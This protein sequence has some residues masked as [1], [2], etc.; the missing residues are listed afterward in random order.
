MDDYRLVKKVFF[1]YN[2]PLP[3]S[4][5][6]ERLFNYATMMNLPKFN[7]YTDENFENRVLTK[8]NASKKL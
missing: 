6:V 1:K 3:S 2:T 5:S 8:A 7:R 4:A